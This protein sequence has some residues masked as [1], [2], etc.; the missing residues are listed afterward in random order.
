VRVSLHAVGEAEPEIV[1]VDR[2]INCT[3]AGANLARQAPPLVRDLLGS[4]NARPDPLGLGLDVAENGG[5]V[6]A[7]GRV[8]ERLRVVGSLRKGV[9]WESIGVTEIRDHS[10]AVAAALFA[11]VERPLQVAS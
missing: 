3:G 5:L 9:E 6:D 2:V 7:A 8:S 1:D 11:T 4:G 10:E